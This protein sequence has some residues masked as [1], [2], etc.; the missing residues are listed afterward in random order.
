MFQAG[1]G[2]FL[3]GY[4]LLMLRR[5]VVLQIGRGGAPREAMVG[6]LGGWIGGLTAMPGAA[7]VFYCN[8][9]GL[10]KAEQRAIVQ[11]F[12]LLMQLLAMAVMIAT[13]RLPADLGLHVALALPALGI[14]TLIGVVLFGRVRET[15]FRRAVLLLLL[16]TGISNAAGHDLFGPGKEAGAMAASAPRGHDQLRETL[17]RHF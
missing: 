17:L 4:A 8:L 7:P 13:G 14:G 6:F 5:P 12:I 1:F 16:I 11:P 15:G 10:A 2:L 9:H 3:A